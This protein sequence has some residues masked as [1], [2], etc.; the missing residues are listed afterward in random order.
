[1]STPTH[2]ITSRRGRLYIHP[3]T[4]RALPSVTNIT[5]MLNK[6]ALPRW[7]AK[8]TALYAVAQADAIAALARDDEAAAVDLLK[9]APWRASGRKA[10]AGTHVHEAV[11]AWLTDTHRDNTEAEQ[12]HVRQFAAMWE[13]MGFTLVAAEAQVFNLD[14]GY[15]G[16]VDVLAE[17]DGQG[18]VLDVKTGKGPYAEHALQLAAYAHAEQ[19]ART[20]GTMADMPEV[21]HAAIVDLKANRSRVIPAD[22]GPEVFR[23][24]RAARVLWEL[25]G[26]TDLFGEAI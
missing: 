25:D 13:R 22:I 17:R 3:G 20:D 10:S 19:V 11:E 14:V 12:D 18:W 5:G 15:A 1:M 4:G 16:S 21:H 6:P 8:E 24:F 2:S 23:A 26:R 9:G 7:A